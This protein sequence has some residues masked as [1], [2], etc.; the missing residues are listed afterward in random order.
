[1]RDARCAMRDARCAM[2]DAWLV[3]DIRRRA[4]KTDHMP[5]PPG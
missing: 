2:R 5:W 1:M 3:V 4:A